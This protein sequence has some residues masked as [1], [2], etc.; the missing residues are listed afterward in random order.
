MAMMAAMPVLAEDF[1]LFGARVCCGVRACMLVRSTSGG[2]VTQ[3][4]VV[5]RRTWLLALEQLPD[6]GCGLCERT[7]E[8][9]RNSSGNYVYVCTYCG[10]EE[11][12]YALVPWWHEHFDY[13]PPPHH[14]QRYQP[15]F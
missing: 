11:P 9:R 5:C 10:V 1:F 12:V 2:F 15:A 3:N 8:R 4:C 7:Y 6:L 13:C 14:F